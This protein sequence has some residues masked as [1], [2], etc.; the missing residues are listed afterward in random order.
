ME[1]KSERIRKRINRLNELL[2]AEYKRIVIKDEICYVASDGT[3][4]TLVGESGTF[5]AFLDYFPSVEDAKRGYWE[6]DG[7]WFDAD[8]PDDEIM[9]LFRAEI[10]G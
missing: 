2:A 3:V 5:S 1:S 8:L 4:F 9:A 10:A 7:D 6:D